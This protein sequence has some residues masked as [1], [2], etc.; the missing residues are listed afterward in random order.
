MKPIKIMLLAC[1]SLMV[2]SHSS[3]AFAQGAMPSASE[4]WEK[5]TRI[6]PGLNDY[7]VDLKIKV[8]AK[9]QFL[10]PKLNLEGTYYF[11]K[12]DKHKL[13]LKRASYFLNK[14]PKIFG[15]SLPPL[16]EFNSR[17]ELDSMGGKDFYKVTLTPKTIAG[18]VVKE[19]IWIDRSNY[20]FPR[21]NYYYK[22]GGS[23]SLQIDYRKEKDFMVYNRMQAVFS[24]P[25]E[26]LD[27]SADASYLKYTMNQGLSDSFFNQ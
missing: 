9:Y 2:L 27:A 10:N 12:P 14:Y 7:S 16:K 8:S 20:T 19:E 3:G 21:H 5:M 22:S 13:Q 1:I 4:L 18:D 24:F 17:V 15:W 11:K 23:I 26:K 6:N 25:S